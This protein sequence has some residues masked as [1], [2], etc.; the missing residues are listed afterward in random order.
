MKR[1]GFMHYKAPGSHRELLT[2]KGASFWDY[3]SGTAG[4][5]RN[6]GGASSARSTEAGVRGSSLDLGLRQF[7]PL[8]GQNYTTPT[9][10][11]GS[12]FPTHKALKYGKGLPFRGLG[13]RTPESGVL[14][15]PTRQLGGTAS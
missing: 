10:L 11:A 4:I 14:H 12:K 9:S 1:E 8:R 13:I 5:L 15:S 6:S 3:V 7:K 2:G